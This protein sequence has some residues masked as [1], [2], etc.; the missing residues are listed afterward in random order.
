M[1]RREFGG[2]RPQHSAE[3]ARASVALQAILALA[4]ATPRTGI[5]KDSIFPAVC[6]VARVRMGD[7][8][9]AGHQIT[10]SSCISIGPITI[11]QN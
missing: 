7:Y 4:P 6:T 5:Q 11:P 8:L 1:R 9:L 10:S 2:M 3:G